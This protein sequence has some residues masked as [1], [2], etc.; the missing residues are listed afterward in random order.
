[1]MGTKLNHQFIDKTAKVRN[2][3]Q[4]FMGQRT[5]YGAEVP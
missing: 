3:M 1:M 2:E 4:L 5:L